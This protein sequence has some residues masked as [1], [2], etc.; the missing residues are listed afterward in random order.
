MI[1]SV[2]MKERK[3]MF[4][5]VVAMLSLQKIH[6]FQNPPIVCR[7][8]Q[9]CRGEICHVHSM[10]LSRFENEDMNNGGEDK[11]RMRDKMKKFAKSIIVKPMAAVAPKAIADI[12]S[13][14]TI[15]ATEIAKETMDD[16]KAGGSIR[17]SVAFS[18]ILEQEAKMEGNTAEALDTIAL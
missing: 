14:A 3:G 11:V 2:T 16:L 4:C 17:S 13:D 12:L 18:R 6:A 10:S 8:V 15:G 1:S 5:V 9:H 7:G